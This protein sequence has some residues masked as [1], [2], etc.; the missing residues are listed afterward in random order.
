MKTIKYISL[1]TAFIMGVSLVLG[2]YSRTF[3]IEGNLLLKMIWG[4]ISLIDVYIMFLL[5]YLWILH[6]ETA[7]LPKILW[8]IL[9]VV[10]G[11]LTASLYLY[12]ACRNA[13]NDWNTLL[14]GDSLKE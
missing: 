3:F 6:R 7:R 13:D 8:G 1:L 2:F 12:F 4:R 5:Y 9:L 14:H 10:F 11:S